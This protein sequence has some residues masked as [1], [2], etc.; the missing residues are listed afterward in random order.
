[1]NLPDLI[2]FVI[3]LLAALVSA[4]VLSRIGMKRRDWLYLWI[5]LNLAWIAGIY[6][7]VL[8]GFMPHSS[9]PAWVRPSAAFVFFSFTMLAWGK[10][11]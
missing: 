5:S 9:Y 1:M 2:I 10:R 4:C 3:A 8:A 11:L 7:L 6:S